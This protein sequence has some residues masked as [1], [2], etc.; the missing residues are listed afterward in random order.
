MQHGVSGTPRMP[1]LHARSSALATPAAVRGQQATD[2]GQPGTVDRNA[3]VGLSWIIT[4]AFLAIAIISIWEK[5]AGRGFEWRGVHD[6]RGGVG[7]Q[8]GMVC[9]C[10]GIGGFSPSL[11]LDKLQVGMA[12][13]IPR[14]GPASLGRRAQ[15]ARA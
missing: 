14:H 12:W 4:V 11:I 9:G 2:A 6:V 13:L 10:G 3:V 5:C 1:A 15:R 8:A 7:A